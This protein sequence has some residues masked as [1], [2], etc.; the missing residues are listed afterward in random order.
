MS[1]YP[2]LQPVHLRAPPKPIALFK[3]TPTNSLLSSTLVSQPESVWN[4]SYHALQLFIE[5]LHSINLM[6]SQEARTPGTPSL[7]SRS[8]P[9]LAVILANEFSLCPITS[10]VVAAMPTLVGEADLLVNTLPWT[11]CRCPLKSS[12]TQATISSELSH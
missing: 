3:T 2:I 7:M 8:L 12:H 10:E 1:T 9:S 11:E 4:V 6:I 5:W